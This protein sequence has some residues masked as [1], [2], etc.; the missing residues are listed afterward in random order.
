MLQDE[1]LPAV[2]HDLLHARAHVLRG[3]ALALA[4]ELDA[5]GHRLQA[6]AQV[7]LPELER[8]V[9]EREAV[10]VEQVEYL[11]CVGGSV[12]ERGGEG[13]GDRQQGRGLCSFFDLSVGR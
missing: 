13:G 1:A 6:R 7:A 11:D 4:D 2:G 10:E 9:E 5:P 12:G 8:F 3:L